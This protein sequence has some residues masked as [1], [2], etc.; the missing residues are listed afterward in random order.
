[1]RKLRF[2]EFILL[3]QNYIVVK[4]QIF[5]FIKK[6]SENFNRIPTQQFNFIVMPFLLNLFFY[7]SEIN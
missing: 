5:G 6:T 3:S 4:Y 7:N 1:M 2:K